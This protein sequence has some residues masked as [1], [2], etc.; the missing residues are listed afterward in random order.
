MNAMRS[1]DTTP[2]IYM[3]PLKGITD[4]LFRQLFWKHFGSI[5]AAVA[6]FI[7]PQRKSG[8]TEK[9]L[10]DVMV[11]NSQLRLIPQLLNTN[12]E[13]FLALAKKLFDLGYEELNWNLG[14]PVPMVARKR[15]GSG[16]LPYPEEILSLLD[17]VIPQLKQSLSIKMRLGYHDFEESIKLLPLLNDYPLSEIIIHARLGEQLYKGRTYPDKFQHCQQYSAH[18]LVYNGD[19]TTP[20]DVATLSAMLG[21]NRWM[22]G[23]GLLANPFLPGEIRGVFHGTHERFVKLELF[24]QELYHEMKERLSGPGHLLGR[25]KQIWIYL[26]GS[27]PDSSKDLKR[28]TK[29]TSER[30]YTEAVQRL[31]ARVRPK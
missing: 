12:S 4:S 22:I 29:A 16:L 8:L 28:I 18:R 20:S 19:I 15:R 30:T 21:I 23:R 2:F 9:I 14:C 27:F 13:D 7:N 17:Q 5:D 24:H 6:P 3:A 10:S 11:R 26:I 25:L 1:T 31:F